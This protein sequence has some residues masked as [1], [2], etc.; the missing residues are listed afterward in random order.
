MK[1][2]PIVKVT[3]SKQEQ[4][5]LR[6]YIVNRFHKLDDYVS[7]QAEYEIINNDIYLPIIE[8]IDNS[9]IIQWDDLFEFMMNKKDEEND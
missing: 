2:V 5:L 4:E 3:F 1:I 8:Q 9:I 6:K 7:I